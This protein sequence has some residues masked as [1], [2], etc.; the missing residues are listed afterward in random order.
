MLLN[1]SASGVIVVA[2]SAGSAQ[3][4]DD[5]EGDQSWAGK[6]FSGDVACWCFL[7]YLF[8]G[9]LFFWVDVTVYDFDIFVAQTFF[10]FKPSVV[11]IN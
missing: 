4:G 9:V 5:C 2:I 11:L 7:N 3:D 6:H 10:I 1:S 8:R